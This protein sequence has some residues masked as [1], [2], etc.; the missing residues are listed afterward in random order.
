[1][2]PTIFL[3]PIALFLAGCATA[4]SAPDSKREQITEVL[5]GV[6]VHDPY[7]WLEDEKSEEVQT[8]MNH[9]DEYAR[10]YL[11][12]T[13]GRAH[14]SE[15]LRELFYANSISTPALRGNRH[16]YTRKHA[17]KEKRIHYWSDT[18]TNEE[19]VLLDPHT[20][21]EDLTTSIG[22]VV[23]SP[24]GELVAYT[25]KRNN[26]DEATLYIMHVKTGVTRKGEIIHGAKYAHPQWLPDSTGF[27]YTYLPTDPAIPTDRRPGHAEIRF[28]KIGKEPTTDRTVHPALHNPEVFLMPDISWDGRWLF[29]IVYHGWTSNDLYLMD[30]KSDKPKWE[31]F[32]VGKPHH[33]SVIPWKEDFY[34]VTNEG[35]PRQRIFKTSTQEYGRN[36][37]VEIVPE[38]KKDVLDQVQLVGGKLL[39]SYLH[40]ATNLLETRDLDGTN[41]QKIP[42]PGIGAASS[43]K[44][45]PE[46]D[47]LYYSYTSFTTPPQIWQVQ[48]STG[49]SEKWAETSLPIQSDDFRVD[50]VWYTSK[51]GTR[52]SMFVIVPKDA[53]QDGTTPFL[54]YGYGGFNISLRPRF[55]GSFYPWLE[56][57]G[58]VAIA[59][60]RGGG[61]YGEQW[62]R[63]GMREKKQNVFDEFI[64]AAEY[65]IDEGWTQPSKLAIQ[66]ASNGGLLVGAVMTQRPELFRA[67][68]C[69]VPLLDMVRYHLFGSG[70]TWISEYGSADDPELFKVL[71]GYSPYHRVSANAHY[72]ATLF[73]AADHDDRVDP[74]HARKM[75]AALQHA[76]SSPHP[77]LLR[78]ERNAGHGGA[79]KVAQSVESYADMLGFL[80]EELGV[81]PPSGSE[82]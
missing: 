4:P 77:V 18:L 6:Q 62:H 15:R 2:R 43:V 64:A 59:N 58:G 14:L 1:M 42:L 11:K 25:L 40:N 36:H 78:I 56:A 7:R 72:P 76:S 52:V 80:F 24:D 20:L 9:Q 26:A 54:L 8:W 57:G 45:H 53:V 37:W 29:A 34:I 61:E 12:E 51:D 5:H 68:I 73:M 60:L 74:M 33:Y 65:L 81:S 79:D 17:D 71:H 30:L 63:D 23:P 19:F 44:G 49:K 22:S 55:R 67:V 3:F 39:L 50:Q 35:A 46:Q 13:P 47:T 28:H 27:F 16:F 82:N 32:V 66:G 75:A 70:R 38:P 21:S 31:P 41:P 10:K 69:G 48:L